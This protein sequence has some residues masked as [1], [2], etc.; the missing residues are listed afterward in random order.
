LTRHLDQQDDTVRAVSDT[1]LD[2]QETVDQ[3]TETLATI[4]ATQAQ[5]GEL[6]AEIL[7]RLDN[8]SS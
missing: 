2:I 6:L 1:V 7:R 3:H 8:G 5:H 4:Q